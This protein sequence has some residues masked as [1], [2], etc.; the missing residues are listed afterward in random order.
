MHSLTTPVHM[1]SVRSHASSAAH[2]RSSA[3]TL[4]SQFVDA[5]CREDSFF[6]YHLK[7][8]KVV[9]QVRHPCS[10]SLQS[11]RVRCARK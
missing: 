9:E 5:V 4:L 3:R 2:S 8:A 7:V 11:K 1:G 6:K 10:I